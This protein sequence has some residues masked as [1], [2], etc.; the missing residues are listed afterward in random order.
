M[1]M[2]NMQNIIA[3]EDEYEHEEIHLKSVANL[4]DA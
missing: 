2:L 3:D 1:M 4:E